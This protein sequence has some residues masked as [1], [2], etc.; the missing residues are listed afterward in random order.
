MVDARALF[1]D[2]KKR[3]EAAG[4]S[5]ANELNVLFET[6][7]GMRYPEAAAA[8]GVSGEQAA[9]FDALLARRLSG[10]PL[11]YIA[12]AWPF[13]DFELL[14]GPG[15]LVPRDET[16]LAVRTALELLR[17]AEAPRVLDL[18]AGSGCI[19]FAL[20]RACPGAAVT[21]VERSAD[22]LGWL[23]RN[24]VRLG[25]A[26]DA[27]QADVFGYETVL[28]DNKYDMIVSNPPYVT[29]A[30]YADNL[31]E[32]RCEPP[33]AFLGGADG[34]DF[35]RY[36][37]PHYRSKLRPGGGMVFEIGAGQAA[38]VEALFAQSGYAGI[39][40]RGDMYGQPRVVSA[41]RLKTV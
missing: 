41:K 6:A 24:K 7:C 21:A 13:L 5:G 20:K 32:L 40:T 12:G 29:S 34:L 16:E 18:C 26:V 10:E 25:C 35:Y 23:E 28:S 4:L 27:M 39:K 37:I 38:A 15:V 19:A 14:V 2:A 3:L 11:Q 8:G 33:E 31:S 17:G 1:A 36:I 9:R 30:E 22:A